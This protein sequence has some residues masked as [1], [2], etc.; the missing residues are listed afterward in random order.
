MFPFLGET[1]HLC[2]LCVYRLTFSHNRNH[3]S[4][5][6][7]KPPPG[8]GSRITIS[9][10]QCGNAPFAGLCASKVESIIGHQWVRYSDGRIIPARNLIRRAVRYLYLV[11]RRRGYH[12]P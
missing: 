3:L 11:A 5:S 8:T 4:L 7:S 6:E 1:S 9:T 2:S 10:T 12:F